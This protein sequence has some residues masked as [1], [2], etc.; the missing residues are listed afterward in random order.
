MRILS[1][2]IITK[3]EGQE[4]AEG[5]GRE[6]RGEGE[7]AGQGALQPPGDFEPKRE[8]EEFGVG[9]WS[10][11]SSS[12]ELLAR[13]MRPRLSVS[14]SLGRV[15]MSAVKAKH[16]YRQCIKL[17]AFLEWIPQTPQEQHSRKTS[18]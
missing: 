1:I 10:L 5:D 14:L 8:E 3:R 7:E 13:A 15:H 11:T 2:H 9:R 18:R 17:F 4:G 6:R 12:H 16:S